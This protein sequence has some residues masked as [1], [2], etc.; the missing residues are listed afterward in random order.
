MLKK[1]DG[2]G[3]VDYCSFECVLTKLPRWH[4]W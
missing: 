2:W 4:R 1:W 3:E